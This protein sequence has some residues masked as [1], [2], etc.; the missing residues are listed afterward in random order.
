MNEFIARANYGLPSGNF[1]MNFDTGEVRFRTSMFV[2]DRSPS[3]DEVEDL[4]NTAFFLMDDYLAGMMRVNDGVS[5]S[6]A[7]TS[8]ENKDS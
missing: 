2:T 8:I 4:L 7:I 6:Q 1:E 5:P 3:Y